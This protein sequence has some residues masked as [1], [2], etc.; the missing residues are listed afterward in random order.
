[1]YKQ[2]LYI[3]DMTILTVA[4]NHMYKHTLYIFDMTQLTVS[5]L[6]LHIDYFVY[7]Y[8]RINNYVQSQWNEV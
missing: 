6:L 1:M 7:Q 2:T 4:S 3:F 8:L 5:L